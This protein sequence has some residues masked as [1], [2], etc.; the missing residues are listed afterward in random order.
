MPDTSDSCKKFSVVKPNN[1]RTFRLPTNGPGSLSSDA[2]ELDRVEDRPALLF[3]TRYPSDRVC[4]REH[5]GRLQHCRDLSLYC[6]FG[7]PS[8]RRSRRVERRPSLT[9]RRTDRVSPC[10]FRPMSLHAQ[11]ADR[12]LAMT[13]GCACHLAALRDWCDAAGIAG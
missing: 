9:C 1:S 7:D 10:S 13:N 5:R 2:S 4:D 11:G 3:L 8:P 12:A 6:V